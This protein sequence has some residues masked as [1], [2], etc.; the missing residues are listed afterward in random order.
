M[1]PA[2]LIFE[3]RAVMLVD[4]RRRD[5]DKQVT[6]HPR[7]QLFLEEVTQDWDIAQERNFR[8]RLV[9]LVL[10]QSANGE[11]IPALDQNV[12]IETARVDDRTGNGSPCEREGGVADLVAD[13]GLN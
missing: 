7:I 13:L 11:R 10:E 12:G 2:H 9:N 5:E 6:F 4:D 3:A 1:Q 8:A